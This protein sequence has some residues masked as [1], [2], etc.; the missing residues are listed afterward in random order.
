LKIP[1]FR[2]TAVP[3][4]AIETIGPP[5]GDWALLIPLL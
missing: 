1:L 2:K 3:P 4:Q 5:A